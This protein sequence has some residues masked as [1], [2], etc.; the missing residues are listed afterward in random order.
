MTSVSAV[1]A[2]DRNPGNGLRAAGL[3]DAGRQREVNEDRFWCDAERGVF[4]VIDGVGGQA[5]GGKAA[6]VALTR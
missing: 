6:D 3:T 4:A 1:A 2:R 5:A